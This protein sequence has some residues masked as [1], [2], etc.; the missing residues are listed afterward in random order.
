VCDRKHI[1]GLLLLELG[2][3]LFVEPLA[4]P[5]NLPC[6]QHLPDKAV[7]KTVDFGFVVLD[8]DDFRPQRNIAIE[9][10]QRG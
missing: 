2:G 4:T 10:A 1:C 6:V 9:P 5:G 8:G 3:D 7:R